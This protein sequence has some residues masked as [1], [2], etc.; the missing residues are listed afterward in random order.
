M[1]GSLGQGNLGVG[2][3]MAVVAEMESPMQPSELQQLLERYPGEIQFLNAVLNMRLQPQG[4]SISPR[5][6]ASVFWQEEIQSLLET[7]FFV[8]QT[9]DD[10]AAHYNLG[11]QQLL[12]VAEQEY[13]IAVDLA[14]AALAFLPD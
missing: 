1:F 13:Q 4:R 8:R 9:L 14:E 5:D 3:P 6:V 2:R 11:P 7:G 10:L 12:Q